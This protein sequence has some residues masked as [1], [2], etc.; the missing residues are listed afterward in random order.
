MFDG[1][2]MW[3]PRQLIRYLES[4]ETAAVPAKIHQPFMLHQSPCRVPGTRRMNATPLPV[5][6][7]L[8]GHISTCC[9]CTVMATSSTAQVTSAT[10]I[11]AIDSWKWKPTWP[12]TC[13]EVIVDARWS[14]GSL[15]FGRTTGYGVPRITT[16]VI[17]SNRSPRLRVF[18]IKRCGSNAL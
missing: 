15:S 10:R 18:T 1:L 8:A 4:S 6:S 7:A 17:P 16:A 3:W 12:I 9:L 2:K 5:R 14:R 13:S 11:C